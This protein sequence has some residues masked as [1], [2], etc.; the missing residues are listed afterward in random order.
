MT[1]APKYDEETG[2]VAY[3][4]EP[5]QSFQYQETGS[6]SETAENKAKATREFYQKQAPMMARLILTCQV[7]D[8]DPSNLPDWAKKHLPA[9]AQ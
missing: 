5:D 9:W 2:S 7:I 4:N 8:F 3:Q 1:L 6:S